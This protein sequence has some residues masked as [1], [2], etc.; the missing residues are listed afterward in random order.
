MIEDIFYRNES[1]LLRS[2]TPN[3][4]SVQVP[5]KNND[6]MKT[7]VNASHSM[8]N[9]SDNLVHGCNKEQLQKLHCQNSN[10]GIDVS[11]NDHSETKDGQEQSSRVSSYK[12]QAKGLSL[13]KLLCN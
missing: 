12:T 7:T 10:S 2:S 11:N 4:L 6:S 5:C 13:V 3:T 9:V 8:P 1:N